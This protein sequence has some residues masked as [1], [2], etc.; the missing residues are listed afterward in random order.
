MNIGIISGW[1]VHA[2]GYVRELI[3]SKK[4]KIT[5]MYD[6]D[7]ERG[8]KWAAELGTA[9]EAD[10]DAFLARPE[11]EAVICNA[12]TTSHP[13]LIGKAIAAGKHVFTEKILAVTTAECEKL[14]KAIDDSGLTFTIALPL[15]GDPQ[16]LYVK[17]LLEDGALGRVT[18]A[19]FRRSH[20]GVSDKWLPDYWF[21]VGKTGGG[22]MMDLGAHPMYILPFLLGE[23]KRLS[24]F[25]SNPYGT[26][27]DE[28]AVAVV[29][30][31]DGI[32]ATGETAFVTY[33]VPDILEVYGTDGSVFMRGDEVLVAN[34]A[35]GGKLVAQKS[36]P[37]AK[38]SPVMQFAEACI[39]GTGSPPCLGTKDA[40]IMTKLIEA[41]YTSDK[42]GKAVVF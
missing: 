41:V 11:I 34:R 15:R 39:A 31:A 2:Q 33:G 12:P 18:G 40:L 32:I 5:A 36:L 27:S 4:V 13:A 38:P 29:E 20:N 26:S 28:N 25:T 9:F 7:P 3:N 8:K 19:R 24:A 1:H 14:C 30:F 37:P 35:S 42:S 17:R 10:Y 16:M 23:P 21:D 22:A 6:E